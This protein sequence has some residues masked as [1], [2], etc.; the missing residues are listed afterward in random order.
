[1]LGAKGAESEA[2]VLAAFL[3]RSGDSDGASSR[4]FVDLS[5]V[6]GSHEERA[7][8]TAW[9]LAEGAE[10]IYQAPL[11]HDGFFGI[12]DFLVRVEG[13]VLACNA[14]PTGGA[15]SMRSGDEGA[16]DCSP[17]APR[18][19]VWD[20]KLARQPKPAMLLQ[21]CC[22]A[23]ML[24]ALQGFPV[25]RV[26]LILGATPLVLRVSAYDALYRRV[27][28][29]FL[30]A[31]ES[32]DPSSMPPLPAPS[33]FTGR[34]S[35][36]ATAELQSRDN[37]RLVARLSARQAGLLK[38]HGV[39]TASALAA[40]DATSPFPI[41]NGLAPSMLRRL[42]RQAALQQQSRA[43]PDGAPAY[44]L[45]RGACSNP[46]GLGALPSPH[47]RDVFFDLEG[48]PFATLPAIAGRAALP[49]LLALAAR[50]D[51]A[52]RDGL[53]ADDSSASGGSSSGE[54]AAGG[55]SQEV[56]ELGGGREY[57]WGVSTRPGDDGS[58][59]AAAGDNCVRWEQQ[60]APT[61]G[62]DA[63]DGALGT[64]LSWWAH[65]T[66]AERAAFASCVDWLVQRT[67]AAP[68]AHIYHYGAYELSVLRR[69]AG[70]YATREAEVDE[71][72][73]SGALIDLYDVVRHSLLLGEPRYSIKN[74]E[75]LY[76]AGLKRDT[77]VAKGDQSVAVYASWLDDPDG[78]EVGD[79]PVLQSLAE[80][81]RDDCE[82]T[83]QLAD[84]LWTLKRSSCAP[85]SLPPPHAF[86]AAE[87]VNARPASD[88][89]DSTDGEASE[90]TAPPSDEEL[91]VL[92]L[93]DKLEA[94]DGWPV[95]SAL[96]HT[97]A[98]ETL[99]GMLRY[100]RRE[101][102]PQWWRRYDWLAMPPSEL[103]GE[104]RTLGG[105]RRTA[106]EPFKSAPKKRRLAYEF[107]FD[108]LQE[109]NLS[110]GAALVLRDDDAF[111]EASSVDGEADEA[112]EADREAQRALGEALSMQGG[113]PIPTVSASLLSLDRTAGLAVLECGMAPP[114]RVS[115]LPN[116]FVDGAP[117]AAALRAHA[118]QMVARP[119]ERTALGEVLARQVPVVGIAGAAGAASTTQG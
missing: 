43:S 86:A 13:D 63:E 71:L 104:A 42:A 77:D 59:E 51:E 53:P 113:E 88:D 50:S 48:F 19:M 65:D 27:R 68:G 85:T 96:A 40:L 98:R 60:P 41:I 21:L 90:T 30:A 47:P 8:A 7:A 114:D 109:C 54:Q 103:A 78:L 56:G 112:D 33:Q 73:R 15:V 34:W 17:A 94:A 111:G 46:A 110:P 108:T 118:A 83:R 12:A 26:G 69:L 14:V 4:G 115:A 75:R 5:S 119:W 91:E 99:R 74:V 28:A 57:L 102:K 29:R 10:V 117:V 66:A 81:N 95:G 11:A 93:E 37:L 89:G 97:G 64:Y 6:R 105:L 80:Y 82:S 22:Y 107:S 79:S 24:S 2:A 35:G 44:E 16:A 25:E 23:E 39:D 36:L 100:H 72:L 45:L 116:E 38:A 101:A 3:Q 61:M 67:R 70:R 32:F 31:Q 1:M 18:Y 62:G 84:W 76:R 58:G 92:R 55:D 49:D 106:T 52:V 87:G 9:A 20:A